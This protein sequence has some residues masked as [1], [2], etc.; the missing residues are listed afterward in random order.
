MK[1]KR[2][3]R[4]RRKGRSIRLFSYSIHKFSEHLLSEALR[5]MGLKCPQRDSALEPDFCCI[6]FSSQVIYCI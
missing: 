5:V 6:L 3:R 4:K 2:R 1:E